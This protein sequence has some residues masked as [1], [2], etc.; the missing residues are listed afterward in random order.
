[1]KVITTKNH[2]SK[3]VNAV[4]RLASS[5]STLPILQNA[6]IGAQTN[7]LIIRATDLEQT[8]EVIIEAEVQD[9]GAITV[10]LRILIDF[11]SNNADERITILTDDLSITLKSAN[12]QVKIKGLPAEDYPTTQKI[13]FDFEVEMDS[14]V[15]NRAI[16]DCLFAS[17]NDDTRPIL[18]GLLMDFT[19]DGLVVVGTDGYRL[20]KFQTEIKGQ[21]GQF[22]IPKR[23]LSELQRLVGEGQVKLGIGSSQVQFT[24]DKTIL[25]SRLI[26]GKFPSYQAIIPKEK[27]LTVTGNSAALLGALKVA[28][29]FSRDSAYSTKLN[30]KGDKIEVVAV[31][32]QLGESRSEV[33]VKNEQGSDFSIS[34][35]SQYMIDVL[36]AVGS[37][38]I[39]EF[40]TESSPIVA[41]FSDLPNYLYLVMPLRSE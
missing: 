30:I 13:K 33:A 6:Y 22:I 19:K 35:N 40:N 27:K 3:A 4:S 12:H 23:A 5:R 9:P 31:S 32:A 21:E 17:A 18:T 11:L 39:L 15:L 24:S 29:L 1:M 34:L 20:A 14:V 28:S 8:I 10:P 41:R 26:D 16:S 25:I 37:D 38:F 36:N 7:E 2:L